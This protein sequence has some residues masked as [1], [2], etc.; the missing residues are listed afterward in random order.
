MKKARPQYSASPT[1]Q[2]TAKDKG[3]LFNYLASSKGQAY[4]IK[5]FSSEILARRRSHGQCVLIFK[6]ENIRVFFYAKHY[7]LGVV[8][9]NDKGREAFIEL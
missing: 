1:P 8:I 4:F 3:S 6:Q 5:R 7:E 2:R 9:K